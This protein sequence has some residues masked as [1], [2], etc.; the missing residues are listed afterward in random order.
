MDGVSRIFG[1]FV[2]RLTEFTLEILHSC[3]K[4]FLHSLLSD[5]VGIGLLCVFLFLDDFFAVT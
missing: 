2:F 3:S 4:R 1:A 5:V